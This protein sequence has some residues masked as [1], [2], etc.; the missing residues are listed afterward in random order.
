MTVRVIYPGTFDPV[1]NG[2][3]E[4]I[5]R[6]CKMFG[7]VIIS[8]AASPSKQPLFDLNHRVSMLQQATQHLDN[9]QIIGFTGLLAEFAKQQQAQVLLRGVRGGNDF[10]YELQLANMN[11][12]LN[13]E[14]ETVI[15]TPSPENCAISSTLVKEIA[16]HGGDVKDLVPAHVKQAL[17]EKLG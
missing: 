5:E 6:A 17:V 12:K 13:P 15:L 8:I 2:H 10:D 3:I 4:L 7:S 14:L 9:V 1:T 11:R 16:K